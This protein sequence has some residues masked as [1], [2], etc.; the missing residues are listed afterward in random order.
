M[1]RFI[2]NQLLLWRDRI[3]LER[4]ATSAPGVR[5]HPR[6]LIRV[7]PTCR[8]TLG[9][10]VSIEAFTV[11]LLEVDPN[12]PKGTAGIVLEIG[13][14]TYIGESNNIRAAGHASIGQNCLISQGVSLIGSNHS[15]DLNRPMIQQPSRKDR[16]GFIIEDDV[17]IGTN[18]TILPGVRIGKGS[19]VAAGSVVTKDI[20]SNVIVAG[21]PARIV[22]RRQ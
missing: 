15:V 18:S 9:R 6:A 10:K 5:I 4:I 11:I 21:V 17:W 13:E 16:L 19:I 22:R 7:A 3:V 8:L 14:G 1:K 2:K 20:P 12:D